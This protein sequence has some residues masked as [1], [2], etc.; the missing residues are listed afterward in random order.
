MASTCARECPDCPGLPHLLSTS[1]K[2]AG[3]DWRDLAG[4]RAAGHPSLPARDHAVDRDGIGRRGRLLCTLITSYLSVRFIRRDLTYH[5]MSG[6][7]A[8]AMAERV[9]RWIPIAARNAA[10]SF[11][12]QKIPRRPCLISTL[13]SPATDAKGWDAS[14]PRLSRS[15]AL[16]AAGDYGRAIADLNALIDSYPPTQLEI[17]VT[18]SVTFALTPQVLALQQRAIALVKPQRWAVSGGPGRLCKVAFGPLG[19]DELR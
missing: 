18:A 7:Y 13:R 6:R 8:Q 5:S 11:S 10:T 14:Q 15:A 2:T 16:I 19:N 3:W 4:C 12:P 1:I 9:N 17:P